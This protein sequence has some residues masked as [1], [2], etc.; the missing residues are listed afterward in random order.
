[1]HFG[2]GCWLSTNC[3]AAAAVFA[4]AA[5]IKGRTGFFL[6]T[7]LLASRRL[8]LWI[9]DLHVSATAVTMLSTFTTKSCETNADPCWSGDFSLILKT[10]ANSSGNWLTR[11][12]N[13]LDQK[14]ATGFFRYIT[15]IN[16]ARLSTKKYVYIYIYTKS[17]FF[18]QNFGIT[19]CRLNKSLWSWKLFTSSFD[20]SPRL[21]WHDANGF[22]D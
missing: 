2:R 13:I 20:V 7:A 11:K 3:F 8:L 21:T 15:S 17:F 1:M 14:F 10:L 4:S 18:L 9:G 12:K 6:Q 16:C 19:C 22:V 5:S